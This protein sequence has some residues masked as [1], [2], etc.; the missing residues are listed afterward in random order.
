MNCYGTQ[1]VNNSIVKTG[2]MGDDVRRHCV[3]QHASGSALNGLRILPTRHVWD[4]L[5]RRL[6]NRPIPPTSLLQLEVSLEQEDPL[7]TA[8]LSLL[9]DRTVF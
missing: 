3:Q 1:W 2:I 7:S 6:A 9:S 4:A 5:G 8:C